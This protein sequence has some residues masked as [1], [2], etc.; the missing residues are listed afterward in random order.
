MAAQSA[1]LPMRVGPGAWSGVL[2]EDEVQIHFGDYATPS[3][4][5]LI[6]AP[7]AR[8]LHDGRVTLVGPDIPR[9][10][11]SVVPFALVVVAWGAGLT[12]DRV[13]ELRRGLQV[14]DQI[15]G[16][17]QC[18]IPREIRFT[19]SKAIFKREIS[20]RHLGHAFIQ[21]FREQ[22]ADFIQ[23]VEVIFLTASPNTIIALKKITQAI[24]SDM[25]A[26]L[27]AKLAQ[28]LKSREDC[29]F[30]WE[31]ADCEYQRICEELRD[32]I[33]MRKDLTA[34]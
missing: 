33:R 12:P 25:A 30:E 18:S 20:F 11:G 27:R 34:D 19:L 24:R 16:F 32:I 28:R 21:L 14:T 6:V 1:G 3:T 2:P 17:A 7:G 5:L 29:E 31:C 26:A 8:A 9:L 22:F 10:S 4:A 15:E 13:R 23:S